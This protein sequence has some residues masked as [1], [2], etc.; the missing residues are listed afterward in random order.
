[1]GSRVNPFVRSW[2]IDHQPREVHRNEAVAGR[3]IA[4]IDDEPLTEEDIAAIE[5]AK[6][7]PRP[8]VRLEDLAAELGIDLEARE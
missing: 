7:D 5:E 4:P 8:G 3:D 6:R 2:T 1:M